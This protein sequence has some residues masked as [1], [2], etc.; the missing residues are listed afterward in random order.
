[1]PLNFWMVVCNAE[2]FRIT[3]E[4]GFNLLG[5]K[6]QHRRKVQRIGNGDRI[7]YYVTHKRKFTA[8]VTATASFFEDDT[9]IWENEGVADWPYRIEIKPEIILED[10]QY[11]DANLLA[12]RLDYVKRWTPE[13]WY[14][15][16]QGNLHLLPKADFL[17]IEEEM[18]KLKFGK[19]YKPTPTLQPPSGNRKRKSGSR[20]HGGGAGDKADAG[21]PGRRSPG[22]YE[23]RSNGGP[24]WPGPA[25][26]WGSVVPRWPRTGAYWPHRARIPWDCFRWVDT[27]TPGSCERECKL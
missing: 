4:R 27:L 20:R 9:P 14:M 15:A 13:N 23:T 12:P 1:M 24:R 16:F 21:G 2:N 7:L 17:L 8:T 3:Q 19:D 11:I 5:L 6:P 18:K 22:S 26:C 25:A 10:S